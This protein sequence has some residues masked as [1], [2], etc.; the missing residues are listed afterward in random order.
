MKKFIRYL[1]TYFLLI[2]GLVAGL[3]VVAV[4]SSIT[5]YILYFI[6]GVPL[7]WLLFNLY[8]RYGITDDP[9]DGEDYFE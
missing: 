1:I 4:K 9:D 6:V 7:V 3:A 2:I 5:A 8:D